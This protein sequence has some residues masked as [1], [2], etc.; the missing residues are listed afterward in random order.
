MD[1][2]ESPPSSL[3]SAVERVLVS[4]QRVLVDRIDLLRLEARED[5]A[6]ALRGATL[7][8]GGAILL[9]YGWIIVVAWVVYMLWGALPLAATL[10]ATA[11]FHV[12][13]GAVL[14]WFGAGIFRGIRLMRPDDPESDRREQQA[15]K[16]GMK[17]AA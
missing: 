14:G 17:G 4:S 8:L 7:V 13:G 9:F 10:G 3:T 11:A 1:G 5:I 12:V 15:L 6:T 16:A 2:I